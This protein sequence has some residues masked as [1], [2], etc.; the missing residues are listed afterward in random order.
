M[1]QENRHY[2]EWLTEVRS[3]QPALSNPEELTAAIMRQVSAMPSRKKR[4]RFLISSWISGIAAALLLCLLISETLFT[5]VP[6]GLEPEGK[7]HLQ[8]QHNAP[9]LPEGWGKMSLT[10]KSDY[11][12]RQYAQFKKLKQG[13]MMKLTK[14]IH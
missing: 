13:R 12:S 2:E 8:Q 6:Y 11:L 1:K 10:E 5:P 7:V 14:K 9:S 4:K 3:R